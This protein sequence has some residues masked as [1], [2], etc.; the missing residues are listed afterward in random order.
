MVFN[1]IKKNFFIFTLFGFVCIG[2]RVGAIELAV[3]NDIAEMVK[4]KKIILKVAFSP[5]EKL[6][7]REMLR[8]SSSNQHI[9]L[10]FWKASA[11][12]K[13]EY[14]ASFHQPKRVF[15]ESFELELTFEALDVEEVFLPLVLEQTNVAVSYVALGKQQ[16]HNAQTA[17]VNCAGHKV[18]NENTNN[19]TFQSPPVSLQVHFSQVVSGTQQAHSSYKVIVPLVVDNEIFYLKRGDFFYQQVHYLLACIIDTWG[20]FFIT[21]IILMTALMTGIRFLLG[22]YPQFLNC[23]YPS[24]LEQ[25]IFFLIPIAFLGIL[26]FFGAPGVAFIGLSVYSLLLGCY[27]LITQS[28]EKDFITK[29]LGLI[30][31]LLIISALPFFLKGFLFFFAG[32]F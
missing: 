5:S 17:F 6:V 14:V 25:L 23:Y 11:A 30:G 28:H 18:S 1:R 27:L 12:A 21:F 10:R 3:L 32:W 31:S 22:K 8:F 29:S 15:T 4:S 16:K 26:G 9:V 24:T 13:T 20:I 2:N 19:E 7:Y